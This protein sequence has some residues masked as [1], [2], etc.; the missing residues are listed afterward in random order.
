MKTARPVPQDR[1]V[2]QKPPSLIPGD[3]VYR[4]IERFPVV[5]VWLGAV[6]AYAIIYLSFGFAMPAL[7]PHGNFTTIYDPAEMMNGINVLIF[8]WPMIWALYRW[9]PASTYRMALDL[10]ERELILVPDDAQPTAWRLST[11]L[12][13]QFDQKYLYYL[14]VFGT[15]AAALVFFFYAVPMQT[16]LA[17]QVNFWYFKPGVKVF[18]IVLFTC[19]NYFLFL[20]LFRQIF[21]LRVIAQY[22]QQQSCIQKIYPLHPDH[23]G[24]FSSVGSLSVSMSMIVVLVFIWSLVYQFHTVLLGGKPL[25]S[26]IIL[27][28]IIY[29]LIIPVM[30]IT[31]LWFP[32]KAMLKY[33][34]SRLR[35]ISEKLLQIT[36]ET[37][38]GI[39][40]GQVELFNINVEWE[41]KLIEQY[42]IIDEQIPVW[43]IG[44][45]AVRNFSITALIPAAI[46]LIPTFIDTINTINTIKNIKPSP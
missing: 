7:Y 20:M 26:I 31:P 2:H 24:G 4:L 19:S 44:F 1:P 18:F 29:I 21:T 17:G 11:K 40:S 41:K 3:R 45:R 5:Y 14:A 6:L 22:F 32:H 25:M 43:P 27:V 46:G 10:E 15:L 38:K 35:E 39:N 12:K 42:K 8:F 34:D 33:K 36:T 28:Y 16:R 23:S 9:F 30:L 37:S 13:Q